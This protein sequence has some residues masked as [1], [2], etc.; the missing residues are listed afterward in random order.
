MYKLNSMLVYSIIFFNI[1][2]VQTS[3]ANCLNLLKFN[4]KHKELIIYGSSFENYLLDKKLLLEEMFEGASKE[5]MLIKKKTKAD[6]ILVKF[7]ESKKIDHP[8]QKI[9][10]FLRN[11][12][13]DTN[14][15][16][17]W[18][19]NL[20]HDMV[21]EIYLN[22]TSL[23]RRLLEE[24]NRIATAIA[25]KVIIERTK[26]GGFQSEN[27]SLV[28]L[29]HSLS[30]DEFSQ[31][32]MN[33]QLMYDKLFESE[34]HGGMIH[35]LQMDYLVYILKKSHQNPLLASQIYQWM[36]ERH[37]FELDE[38]VVFDS[39]KNGWDPIFDSTESDTSSPE[40]LNPALNA[41]FRWHKE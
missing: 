8:Y 34:K 14:S 2:Y 4:I 21:V 22:G 31:I 6:K 16:M 33:K 23:E 27:G 3:S 41:F 36:G 7:I 1:L 9:L 17:D 37:K 15:L 5:L 38:D 11:S 30:S 25:T 26:V 28:M 29:E 18:V 19:L 32:L 12:T 20:H 10:K 13:V 35:L 39:L 24:E 40:F